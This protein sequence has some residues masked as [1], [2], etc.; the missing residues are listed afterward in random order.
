[1]DVIT[2]PLLQILQSHSTH[3]G[4]ISPGPPSVK[5]PSGTTAIPQPRCLG[6]CGYWFWGQSGRQSAFA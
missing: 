1:M 3:A 5:Y 6:Q 2:S 4:K